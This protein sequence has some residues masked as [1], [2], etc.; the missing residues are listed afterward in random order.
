MDSFYTRDYNRLRHH[1][2]IWMGLNDV[3]FNRFWKIIGGDSWNNNCLLYYDESG[4]YFD[5]NK[6]YPIFE[7]ESFMNDI[8]MSKNIDYRTAREL[9]NYDTNECEKCKRNI[10]EVLGYIIT[11]FILIIIISICF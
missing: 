8:S 10:G 3:Q 6:N 9:I 4:L 1:L 2:F 5:S 11:L 7:N